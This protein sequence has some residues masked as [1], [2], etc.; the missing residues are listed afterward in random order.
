[1]S[2][3]LLSFLKDLAIVLGTIIAL[4][5]FLSGTVE[6]ARQGQQTRAHHFL[7]MRRRF[8]ETTNHRDI[9]NLLTTDDPALAAFPVQDR[10]NL[11]GFL[12]E[13]ALMV[14]SRLI[15]REVA[16]YM[17]GYYALLCARS[18]HLWDGLDRDSL[19]WTVFREFAKDMSE[20]EKRPDFLPKDLSF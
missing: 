9:L 20:F 6:Y 7:Q 3:E 12:E 1:M 2:P 14:N 15:R 8:L 11:I 18:E 16:G 10:R 5:T 17:F 19:Y 4:I 13:I